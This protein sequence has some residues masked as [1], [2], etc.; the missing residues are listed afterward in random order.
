MM[1]KYE[2]AAVAPCAVKTVRVDVPPTSSTNCGRAHRDDAP[3]VSVC[4]VGTYGE[5]RKWPA[6]HALDECDDQRGVSNS[7]SK[8]S[9]TLGPPAFNLRPTAVVLVKRGVLLSQGTGRTQTELF[10][11]LSSLLFATRAPSSGA[12]VV[13]ETR[14]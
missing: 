14:L 3:I 9:E 13:I 11:P 1:N 12:D 4:I 2:F 8:R 5:R 7:Q 6:S 10:L